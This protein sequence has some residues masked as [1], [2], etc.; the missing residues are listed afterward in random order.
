LKSRFAVKIESA[1]KMFQPSFIQRWLTSSNCES[2]V[3]P[4]GMKSLFDVHHNR[5]LKRILFGKRWAMQMLEKVGARVLVFDWAKRH[6]NVT[7]ALLDAAKMLKIPTVGVPHGLKLWTL[8]SMKD[9]SFHIP[10]YKDFFQYDHVVVPNQLFRELFVLG[11]ITEEKLHV[12][13]S[14]RFCA[15]WEKVYE[16]I[17]PPSGL[18]PEERSKLKVVFMEGGYNYLRDEDVVFETVSKLAR[19]DFVRLIVKAKTASSRA[20][21]LKERVGATV[22]LDNDTPSLIL[23]KW[24]D[25][26]IMT[27]TSIAFEVYLQKKVMLYPKYF[28]NKASVL[29]DM[30]VAWIVDSYPQLEAA[31]R[32]LSM[33]PSYC[34]YSQKNVDAFLRDM[35]YAGGEDMDVLGRYKDFIEDIARRG[36]Q[37]ESGAGQGTTT[38]SRWRSQGKGRGGTN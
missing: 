9:D 8:D 1:Y 31:L 22:E 14:A 18:L 25:A 38:A 35:V 12:L 3:T 30:K 29:E 27:C 36:R 13:G 19:L 2:G 4:A 34:P 21:A 32:R 17:S 5:L 15:A 26:V 20:D 37:S 24:A 23:C 6:Q 33:E 28:Y 11:G 10:N 7:G 16:E